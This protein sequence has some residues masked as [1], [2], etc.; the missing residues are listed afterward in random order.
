[1][2]TKNRA[3]HL[4]LKKVMTFPQ[5]YKQLLNNLRVMWGIL[6]DANA[7]TLGIEEKFQKYKTITVTQKLVILR[8][9]EATKL[10]WS[11]KQLESI[12]Q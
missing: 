8:G 2:L 1:M 10:A 3:R 12:Q 11:P 6:V 7:R 4:D 9:P 5:S